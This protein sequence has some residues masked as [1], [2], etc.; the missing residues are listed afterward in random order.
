MGWWVNVFANFVLR[1]GGPG[2]HD[3]LVSVV[4]VVVDARAYLGR[5]DSGPSIIGRV[6]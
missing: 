5:A 2:D 4:V 3:P 6:V 1:R